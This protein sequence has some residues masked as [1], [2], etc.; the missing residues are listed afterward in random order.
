MSLKD[1]TKTKEEEEFEKKAYK[2]TKMSRSDEEVSSGS[3][4]VRDSEEEGLD[5]S[6]KEGFHWFHAFFF[7]MSTFAMVLITNWQF[8]EEKKG[9]DGM[10]NIE[11][12]KGFQI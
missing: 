9:L 12:E 11:S 6:Y 2:M 3:I 5:K 4:V 1:S 7:L 10:R 8:E